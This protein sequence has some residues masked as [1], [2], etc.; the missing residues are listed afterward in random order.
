MA[1]PE[2]YFY[3]HDNYGQYA[4]LKDMGFLLQV[5]ILSLT[6]HYGKQVAKAARYLFEHDLADLVGTD[7]HHTRHLAT[8]QSPENLI[9]FHKHLEKKVYNDLNDL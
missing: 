9:L 7:M 5:N 3:Y 1:H 2:R 8:M 4:H 6:G